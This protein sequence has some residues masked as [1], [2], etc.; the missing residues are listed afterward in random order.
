MRGFSAPLF[1]VPPAVLTE[2]PE[3]VDFSRAEP[4]HEFRVSVQCPLIREGA[5]LGLS[6][7]LASESV[8]FIF[9]SGVWDFP[10]PF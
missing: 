9:L 5:G 2:R 8:H 10:F 1:L 4:F 6:R 3:G 7:V